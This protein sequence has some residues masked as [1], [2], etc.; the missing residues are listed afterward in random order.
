[1]SDS[2]D[3]AAADADRTDDAVAVARLKQQLRQAWC[4]ESAAISCQLYWTTGN[5]ALGQCAVTALI[6]QDVLGGEIVCS[7]IDDDSPDHYFNRL[8]D[9]RELD[10]TLEM[11][12]AGT[13]FPPG[14]AVDRSYILTSE[15][16]KRAKMPERY[17]ILKKRWEAVASGVGK[18]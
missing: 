18:Q 11:F 9:G 5:P 14:E 2:S 8:P 3:A 10:L 6:V 16:A 12:P 13:R 15:P 7:S 4:R 1:M 17:A